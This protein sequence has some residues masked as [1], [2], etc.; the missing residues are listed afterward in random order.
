MPRVRLSA[1]ATQP[2][3]IAQQGTQDL[4][5]SSLDSH[6]RIF[7]TSRR[8]ADLVTFVGEAIRRIFWSEKIPF[9]QI[10]IW[11]YTS[12]RSLQMINMRWSRVIADAATNWL[13]WVAPNSSNIAWIWVWQH[14]RNEWIT[15]RQTPE[16]LPLRQWTTFPDADW[17]CMDEPGA[18]FN[19]MQSKA[20]LHEIDENF[21]PT[22]VFWPRFKLFLASH[23]SL[24]YRMSSFNLILIYPLIPVLPRVGDWWGHNTVY[25]QN[26]ILNSLSDYCQITSWYQLSLYFF[27]IWVI[28]APLSTI[29]TTALNTLNYNPILW[30]HTFP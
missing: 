3:A 26:P 15:T 17:R 27:S 21:P 20:Q 2:K 13:L 12:R 9:I 25:T 5:N 11:F 6:F 7:V 28:Q 30:K 29:H 8:I 14:A 18:G 1:I 23:G 24:A 19:P 10:D 22:C 16:F 4:K